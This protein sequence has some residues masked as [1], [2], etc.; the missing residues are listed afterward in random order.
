MRAETERERERKRER[1]RERERYTKR[2]KLREKEYREKNSK[3]PTMTSISAPND[4]SVESYQAELIKLQGALRT[5][6][7]TSNCNPIFV[8]L[9]WH[10]S[11]T[12]DRWSGQAWPRCGGANGSIR[13][14]AE[15]A[16]G[17]NAGLSKAIRF[18]TPFKMKFPAISW[19]DLIQ[20]ASAESLYLAG[21]PPLPMKYGR[22]DVTNESQ[23]PKEGNLPDAEAPWQ[24]E[25][26][27]AEHLRKIFSRMGFS[28]RDIVALSG[29]HTLG[30]AFRE[31][32]GTTT[33]GYGDKGASRYTTSS[34]VARG[35]G[36]AGVG[37]SG[38]KSWTKKWLS[39]DNSVRQKKKKRVTC[40]NDHLSLVPFLSFIQF[41]Q[42]ILPLCTHL[43]L[44]FRSHQN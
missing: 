7:N 42:F 28:D 2:E 36:R 27:A 16:H 5:F 38:G 14:K 9:A 37:M 43:L 44:L 40:T 34:A 20:M 10:D 21:C 26:S 3:D 31:R 12:F 22:V 13:F 23:C 35:D 17:G 1:E 33:N 41:I 6:I 30:R 11:A 4:E 29:A 19:A 18:L 24:G 8:R 32:S 15:L 25:R 39:F